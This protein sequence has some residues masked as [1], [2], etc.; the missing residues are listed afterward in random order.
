MWWR[1]MLTILLII[2][3]QMIDRPGWLI[4]IVAKLKA[5]NL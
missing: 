2:D 3:Q 1:L 4:D 5:I